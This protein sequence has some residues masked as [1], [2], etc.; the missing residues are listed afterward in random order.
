MIDCCSHGDCCYD[1]PTMRAVT[2]VTPYYT[3]ATRTARIYID[4]LTDDVLV[5]VVTR[6]DDMTADPIY[7]FPTV[8]CC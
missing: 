4:I 1:D 7:T 5:L 8:I 3:H 6:D 2:F